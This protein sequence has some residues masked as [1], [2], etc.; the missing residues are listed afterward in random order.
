MIRTMRLFAVAAVGCAV[1]LPAQQPATPAAPKSNH[2]PEPWKSIPVPP[3]HDFK[4]PQPRRIVLDNGLVIFLQE[5]HELPFIDGSIL[6]RGGSRDEPAA[7]GRPRP[8]L[9]RNLAHQRHS[10]PSA[11]MRSTT[12]SKPGRHTLRRAAVWPRPPSAGP[13]SKATSTPSSPR[14]S[15]SSSTPPS[16]RISSAS[17]SARS[18]PASPAGTTTRAAS[19]AAKPRSSSTASPAPTPA[20][21]S[22]PPSA[23]SPST[24]STRGTPRPSFP[25]A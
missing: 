12:S 2:G 21:R 3:L 15:T 4:P 22:T 18:T 25:T 5:D 24:T 9:R 7:K 16:K 14:P 11:E 19:R 6:I 17:P 1:A 13:A 8:P 10:P 23:P 20:G